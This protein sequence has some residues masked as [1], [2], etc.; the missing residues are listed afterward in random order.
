MSTR[1]KNLRQIVDESY[2]DE[3]DYGAEDDQYRGGDDEDYGEE[4]KK[5]AQ[6][7]KKA[8]SNHSL[9]DSSR[10]ALGKHEDCGRNM[11]L[12]CWLLYH[13]ASDSNTASESE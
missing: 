11:C 10:G 2:Y 13:R 5:P 3:D 6:K 12:V 9:S 8:K 4:V 7:K 1:H